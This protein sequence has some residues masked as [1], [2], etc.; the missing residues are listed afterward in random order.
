MTYTAYTSS[1]RPHAQLTYFTST[2]AQKLTHTCAATLLALLLAAL[3]E[4]EQFTYFT[5][6]VY[7]LYY[8]KSTNIDTHLR[9]WS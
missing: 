1:L 7:L 5:S 4:L 9:C 8:Y 6:T 3:L 2:K